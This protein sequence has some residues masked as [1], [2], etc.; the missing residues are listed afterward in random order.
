[1]CTIKQ[2]S[3]P[4]DPLAHQLILPKPS[5]PTA[6]RF[7]NRLE[8]WWNRPSRLQHSADDIVNESIPEAD[9]TR[10][11]AT[12]DCEDLQEWLED[13]AKRTSILHQMVRK[14][15]KQQSLKAE[16]GVCR[17][18]YKAVLCAKLANEYLATVVKLLA[19]LLANWEGSPGSTT[20]SPDEH[21]PERNIREIMSISTKQI[22]HQLQA[23]QSELTSLHGPAQ[24]S[25]AARDLRQTRKLVDAVETTLFTLFN[26]FS[27]F[28]LVELD[29]DGSSDSS[30]S[31]SCA[32]QDDDLWKPNSS[33]GKIRG[34]CHISPS[35]TG[36]E[37]CAFGQNTDFDYPP[38]DKLLFDMVNNVIKELARTTTNGAQNGL[39]RSWIMLDVT[40]ELRQGL[41]N[42][43]H[44]TSA[45]TTLNDFDHNYGIPTVFSMERTTNIDCR[46]S[47]A[48]TTFNASLI[49]V[50]VSLSIYGNQQRL[51]SPGKANRRQRT[52][53]SRDTLLRLVLDPR[54]RIRRE[55]LPTRSLSMPDVEK[56]WIELLNMASVCTDLSNTRARVADML[57]LIISLWERYVEYQTAI[58]MTLPNPRPKVTDYIDLTGVA[59]SFR[60]LIGE[61][62]WRH[63]LSASMY[64]WAS[65]AL[66]YR[67]AR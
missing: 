8:S 50:S 43:Y 9:D 13:R 27:K 53:K 60:F 31:D 33:R 1:L 6:S 18:T 2:A 54:E 63:G 49:K 52:A 30:V 61:A 40:E 21:H 24:D 16:N 58:W 44:R 56:A 28:G 32:E 35:T 67:P 62:M 66:S 41:A 47:I 42:F 22:F 59:K 38:L 51:N 46:A 57:R 3:S 45:P 19:S 37:V 26:G 23:V 4:A 55:Q 25:D 11:G 34:V 12:L 14:T 10:E 5:R 48:W 20:A 15:E 39:D 7:F 29:V 36:Q 17:S 65:P 64:S